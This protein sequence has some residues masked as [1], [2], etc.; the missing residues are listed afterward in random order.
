MAAVRPDPGPAPAQLTAAEA[1]RRIHNG[2][3]TSEEWTQS[4]LEQIRAIDPTVQ[5]WTHLDEAH[6]LAQARAADE[7]RR[8]G[9]A[10]GPLC[11]APVGIKDIIDTGDMPTENGT[12]LHKGRT[13]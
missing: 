5:A 2:L 11:G 9:R 6:A 4:C 7:L 1:I 10:A 8:S 12:P 13:P 3:L